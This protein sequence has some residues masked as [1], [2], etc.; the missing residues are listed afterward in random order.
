MFIAALDLE[1]TGL[2]VKTDRITEIGCVLWHVESKQPV[3]MYSAFCY[4]KSY[5]P[6]SPEITKLTGITQEYLD[7]F[8]TDLQG[9]I[10]EVLW[11]IDRSSYVLAHNGTKFDRPLFENE[12]KRINAHYKQPIDWIDSS[13]DVPYPEDLQIRKLTYLAAEHG[14][15][16]PFPHRALFDVMTMLK[17]ISQYEFSEVLRYFKSPNV[18][19]HALVSF[20]NK[21]LARNAGFRWD[22]DIKRW[23]KVVKDFQVEKEMNRPFKVAQVQGV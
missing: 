2:N 5:P 23:V 12:M 10:P 17:I 21:D 11:M 15:I 4:D 7:K 22:A 9:A 13:V 18:T 3:Q 14:F 16:N 1:T 20:E 19:L 8:S 6:L